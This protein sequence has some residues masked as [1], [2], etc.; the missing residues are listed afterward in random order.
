AP[1]ASVSNNI[2]LACPKLFLIVPKTSRRAS[3][4]VTGAL[5]SDFQL[6][7]NSWREGSL[8]NIGDL[9]SVLFMR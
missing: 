3:F 6:S 7:L 2:R 1:T 4:I 5:A 9:K 8:K